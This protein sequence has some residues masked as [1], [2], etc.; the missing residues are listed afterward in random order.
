MRTRIQINKHFTSP[1]QSWFSQVIPYDFRRTDFQQVLYCL[2][3]RF[4]FIKL[5]PVWTI[6]FII[7]CSRLPYSFPN[8]LET[9]CCQVQNIGQPFKPCFMIRSYFETFLLVWASFESFIGNFSLYWFIF[10]I[11]LN[12]ALDLFA[13]SNPLSLFIWPKNE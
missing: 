3:L 10:H 8:I 11:Y 12:N 4:N 9:N 5:P 1:S 7:L 13:P 2:H 6:S